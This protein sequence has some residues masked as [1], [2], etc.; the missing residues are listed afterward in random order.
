MIIWA[1]LGKRLVPD[2]LA[3]ASPGPKARVIR[4]QK[5]GRISMGKTLK[6]DPATKK[7][8]E[9]ESKGEVSDTDRVNLA[10]EGEML[11]ALA[12]FA[13]QDGVDLSGR[14][15][16]GKAVNT[17][18]RAFIAEGIAEMKKAREK[19]AADTKLKFEP[20]PEAKPEAKPLAQKPEVKPEAKPEVKISQARPVI[21]A[22][23]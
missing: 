17:Y 15:M 6:Y 22:R 5:G 9:V 20:K 8:V 10:I 16:L 3:G 18:A 13:R 23:S 7:V 1:N 14:N 12:G 4:L 2:A 11:E 19:A 21:P